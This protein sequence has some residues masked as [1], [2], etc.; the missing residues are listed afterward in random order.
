MSPPS[1]PKISMSSVVSNCSAAATRASMA[2]P[3][4]SNVRALDA[5]AADIAGAADG[6]GDS[7]GAGCCGARRAAI[8]RHAQ[9]N[10]PPIQTNPETFLLPFVDFISALL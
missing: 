4:V 2:C 1:G 7:F 6:A 10:A 9:T 3:G 5:R 8:D